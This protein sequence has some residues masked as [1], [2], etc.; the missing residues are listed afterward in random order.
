MPLEPALRTGPLV[1]REV[2]EFHLADL[3]RRLRGV[4]LWQ[5]VRVPG[6]QLDFT[7][8]DGVLD[9]AA[10]AARRGPHGVP[11]RAH[12]PDGR[13]HDGARPGQPAPRAGRVRRQLGARVAGLRAAALAGAA[14]AGRHAAPSRC[15]RGL[16][17]RTLTVVLW[18][19]GGL[20]GRPAAAA[21]GR[22][23]RPG[24]R[25]ARRPH[26]VPLRL[27]RRRH[28]ASAAGGAARAGPAQRALLRE[29]C[30]H[31]RARP[32][33]AAPAA[34][35]GRDHPWSSAWAPAS[36]RSRCCTRTGATP[37]PRRAVPAVRQLLPPAPRRPRA[38]LPQY[39]RIVRIVDAHAAGRDTA[40]PCRSS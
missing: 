15:R 34:G 18:S 3:R 25:R 33:G 6:D 12:P 28:P 7:W 24:V 20:R 23:R 13:Q 4:R 26:D 21:A 38:A 17:A 37:T 22:A 14:V 35:R 19:A 10:R 2:V 32:R 39:A 36:A 1:D 40:R 27:D 31:A 11:V 5:E 9:A 8:H 29:R 30:L 16:S